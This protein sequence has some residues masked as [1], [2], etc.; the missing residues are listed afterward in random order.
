[1]R[2][3]DAQVMNRPGARPIVPVPVVAQT[4][5]LASIADRVPRLTSCMCRSILQSFDMQQAV[6]TFDIVTDSDPSI[7]PPQVS[8]NSWADQS[9]FPAA[10]Q[11]PT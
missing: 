1:M 9:G 2:L 10:H 3:H 7:V 5:M 4:A 6:V 8:S 11:L